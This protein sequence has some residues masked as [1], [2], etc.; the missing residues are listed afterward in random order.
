MRAAAASSS[1]RR[2]PLRIPGPLLPTAERPGE[3]AE[4]LRG[5]AALWCLSAPGRGGRRGA[6]GGSSLR[7]RPAVFCGGALCNGALGGREGSGPSCPAPLHGG[8]AVDAEAPSGARS[9][10]GGAAGAELAFR[11]RGG[12]GAGAGTP[13]WGAA[14][15]AGGAVR[16]W[17]RGGALPARGV[18]IPVGPE[19]SLAPPKAVGIPQA[20]STLQENALLCFVAIVSLL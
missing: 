12:P 2:C 10:R 11:Q 4:T 3:P 9:R 20:P 1:P 6:G 19:P 14:G 16:A 8:R 17:R 5:A 13:G 18:S 7:P 15:V